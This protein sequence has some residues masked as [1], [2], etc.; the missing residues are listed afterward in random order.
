MSEH[1]KRINQHN[2]N[3]L[4]K[5]ECILLLNDVYNMYF[6]NM[7]IFSDPNSSG[8]LSTESIEYSANDTTGCD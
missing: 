3:K 6:Y 5:C 4:I 2:S 1:H 7:L 8:K